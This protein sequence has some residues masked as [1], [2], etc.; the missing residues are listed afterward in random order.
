MRYFVRLSYKGTKYRG[1][2]T[3]AKV[4]TIQE[5][6]E[7]TLAKMTGTQ[8]HIHGCGRTDAEVHASNYI[9]HFD[10]PKAFDYDPVFRLNKM[11]PPD[12]RIH[13]IFPVDGKW[14]A[15]LSA[16]SRT[17]QYHIYGFENP[18]LYETSWYYP[19]LSTLKIESMQNAL[20]FLLEHKEYYSLC[21]R[22]SIYPHTRCNVSHV[23][24]KTDKDLQSATVEIKA[25]RFLKSMIRILVNR[26]V[27]VGSG[28]LS[29]D[30]FKNKLIHK[31]AFSPLTLA[32]PQGLHLVEVEYPSDL[33]L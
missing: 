24:L 32:P 23:S 10:Y 3:Q 18:F 25:N 26:L 20:D 21:R 22:P 14:D 1:W 28:Q 8:R 2:Q 19:K 29:V 13:E 15:Q 4:K 16:L 33:G 7:N 31:K 27:E 9:A 12:I 11:L 17:Y 30:E 5:T 6:F